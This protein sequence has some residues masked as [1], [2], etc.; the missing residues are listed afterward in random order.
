VARKLRSART[1]RNSL[2]SGLRSRLTR[3]SCVT[4]LPRNAPTP[5]VE[6]RCYG[7]GRLIELAHHMRVGRPTRVM[8]SIAENKG[9]SP[10]LQSR[11][12]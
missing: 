7:V 8:N 9:S 4:N 1:S 11:E 12:D 2:L 10:K 6:P 3:V 5:L